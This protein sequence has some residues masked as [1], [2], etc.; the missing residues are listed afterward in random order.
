MGTAE[1]AGTGWTSWRKSSYSGGTGNG[2]C[3]EIALGPE[4][5]G[6]R[7]SKNVAGPTL[8]FSSSPWQAFITRLA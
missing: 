1:H 5:V 4:A 7:D 2:G 6:V 3:V 8:T